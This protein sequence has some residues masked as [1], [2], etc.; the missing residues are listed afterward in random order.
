MSLTVWAVSPEYFMF[1]SALRHTPPP[2]PRLNTEYTS[3]NA[4]LSADEAKL[5]CILLMASALCLL[6]AMRPAAMRSASIFIAFTATV[7]CSSTVRSAYL[8]PFMLSTIPG[9]IAYI[10]AGA[11]SLTLR[12]YSSLLAA[13]MFR[14]A[15]SPNAASPISASRP[16]SD[17]TPSR[18]D[19]APPSRSP[20][21]AL[22]ALSRNFSTPAI[23][24]FSPAALA[25]FPMYR[26]IAAH[27]S[28]RAV[29]SPLSIAAL[30]AASRSRHASLCAA[31]RVRPIAAS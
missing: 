28:I 13:P 17:P 9:S 20:S 15:G 12:R 29:L 31:F 27:H 11:L 10:L 14:A 24:A 1:D 4:T 23:A 8:L 7:A 22:S 25:T 3:S 21:I 26:S 16:M 2:L 19:S 5:L 18:S 6:S 30:C